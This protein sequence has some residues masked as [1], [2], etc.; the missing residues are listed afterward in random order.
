[1]IQ[2]PLLFCVFALFPA[3]DS[4]FYLTAI[5]LNLFQAAL[6]FYLLAIH[7]RLEV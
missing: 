6:L 4:A 2:V 7:P 3:Y 5:I 1:L